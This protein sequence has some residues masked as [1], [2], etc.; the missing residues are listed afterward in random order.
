MPESLL[1]VVLALAGAMHH[2]GYILML[3]ARWNTLTGVSITRA[4]ASYHHAVDGVVVLLH[5][6]FLVLQQVVVT[7]SVQ[8]S[9]GEP[10]VGRLQKIL[11]FLAV[12]VKP[13][14][15]QLDV[16]RKHSVDYLGK[17][18]NLCVETHISPLRWLTG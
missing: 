18:Q 14:R 11:H 4:G 3:R 6:L 15:V 13:G 7:E 8:S 16:G 12:R 17:I 10:Q 1:G 9:E 2:P 5:H